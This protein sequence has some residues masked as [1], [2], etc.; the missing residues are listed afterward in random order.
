MA[1]FDDDGPIDVMI[2]GV[3]EFPAILFGIG[4]GEFTDP[5]PSFV[6][7]LGVDIEAADLDD[8]GLPD[9]AVLDDDG[10]TIRVAINV[11]DEPAPTGGIPTEPGGNQPARSDRYTD[12]YSA[13][14]HTNRDADVDTDS[15]RAAQPLRH[16][17]RG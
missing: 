17:A 3:T 8:D 9:F 13:D 10:E 1:D 6:Q 14:Q 11:S 2:A 4:T 12:A 5:A 15:H 7:V 16:L